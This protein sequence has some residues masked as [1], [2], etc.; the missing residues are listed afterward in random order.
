M[1]K[2]EIIIQTEMDVTADELYAML[3]FLKGLRNS[4]SIKIKEVST[5]AKHT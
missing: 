4:D 5:N 2:K 3:H 1:T